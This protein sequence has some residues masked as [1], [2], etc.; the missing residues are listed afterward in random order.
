VNVSAGVAEGFIHETVHVEYDMPGPPDSLSRRALLGLAG[1]AAASLAGCSTLRPDVAPPPG[2]T[3]WPMSGGNPQGSYHTPAGGGPV[4]GVETRWTHE[5]DRFQPSRIEPLLY[6]DTLYVP[7]ISTVVVDTPTGE[8]RS[9]E[10][11]FR[12]TPALAT[13]TAYRNETLV[14]LQRAPSGGSPLGSLF[15]AFGLAGINPAPGL[16]RL[17]DGRRRWNF[18]EQPGSVRPW[19][20]DTPAPPVVADGR[21]YLGG[22]WS[23][24]ERTV[25]GIAALDPSNG[26][27]DWTYTRR[28]SPESPI[29]FGRPS[30][31]EGD[32]YAPTVRHRIH[33]VDTSDGSERWSTQVLDDAGASV[34]PVVATDDIVVVVEDEVVVGLQ[35][36]DGSEVWRTPLG[37]F[38]SSGVRRPVAGTDDVVVVTVD[39]DPPELVALAT[40]TGEVRWRVGIERPT[41]PPVVAGGVVYAGTYEGVTAFDAADGSQRWRFAPS[42][43]VSP[44]ATPVVGERGLYV[45]GRETLYALG[46][47]DG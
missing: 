42:D 34:P 5:F 40:A 14:G 1:G 10:G 47:A 11:R 26:A 41:S 43:S 12:S 32:A 17:S 25:G 35:R 21:V 19:N 44:F 29:P 31:H 4:D 36:T 33:A 39:T 20:T 7:G 24:A 2:P 8:A 6:G 9:F 23:T 37:G 30:V 27:V 16:D 3:D 15:P 13:E 45:A 38:L 46:E 22:R 18:P 28:T